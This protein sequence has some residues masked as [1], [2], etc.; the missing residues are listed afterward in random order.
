MSHPDSRTVLSFKDPHKS[1]HG[2]QPFDKDNEFT[3]DLHAMQFTVVLCSNR[4]DCVQGLDDL[5]Y[6]RNSL[7]WV[8]GFISQWTDFKDLN[9]C[10]IQRL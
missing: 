3:H 1:Y 4:I 5:H 9:S 2:L 10:L 7:N 8:Q 6:Y